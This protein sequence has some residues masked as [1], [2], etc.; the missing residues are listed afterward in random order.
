LWNANRE[1]KYGHYELLKCGLSSGQLI[2]KNIN[3]SGEWDGLD[4]EGQIFIL[5]TVPE[6]NIG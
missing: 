2:I 1:I 4:L 3:R 6:K 5:N